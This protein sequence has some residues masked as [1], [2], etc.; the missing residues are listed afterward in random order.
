MALKDRAIKYCQD[1]GLNSLEKNEII[2]QC[3]KCFSELDKYPIDYEKSR[4]TLKGL[5]GE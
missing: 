3:D 4:Q 1:K 2:K 5:R